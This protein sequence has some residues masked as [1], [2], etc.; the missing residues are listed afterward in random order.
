MKVEPL[1]HKPQCALREIAADDTALDTDRDLVLSVHSMEMRGRMVSWEDAD[2]K[3]RNLDISGIE[4]S[5]V[6]SAF[7]SISITGP[8]AERRATGPPVR[9]A[10][11]AAAGGRTGGAQ[12]RAPFGRPSAVGRTASITCWRKQAKR[13][14]AGQVH[15]NVIRHFCLR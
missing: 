10:C 3:P 8:A 5:Y 11:S 9:A 2:H 1:K 14:V 13:A 7:S 6:S 4:V 12:P 15:A